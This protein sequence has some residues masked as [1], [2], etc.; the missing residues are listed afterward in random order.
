MHDLN[1]FSLVDMVQLGAALRRIA[2]DAPCLET[3]AGRITQYLM[4]HLVDQQT[5][6]QQCALVRFFKTHPFADLPVPLQEFARGVLE[7]RQYGPEVRCLTLLGSAGIE[8]EWNGRAGSKGHQ[9]IPLPSVQ[10]VSAAPMIASLIRQ[11][12]LDIS[13]VIEPSPALFVERG[14]RSFNV[15]HVPQALGSPYL[16]A[17]D[18][19]V[20]PCGIQ[21]VLGCGGLLSTGDLFALILFSRTAIDRGVAEMFATVALNIKVAIL[22]LERRVFA[23]PDE[24][25]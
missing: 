8:P 3:A 1:D 4:T 9:A 16:P 11:L 23:P 18:Q 22:P 6:E 5:H 2:A 21:S 24:V 13:A 20:K 19:F 7:E 17:Q 10:I 15:F 25:Q 14:Q 12:G